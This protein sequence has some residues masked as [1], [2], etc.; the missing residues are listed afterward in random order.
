MSSLARHRVRRTTTTPRPPLSASSVAAAVVT[1]LLL[2]ASVTGVATGLPKENAVSAKHLAASSSPVRLG[3]AV[4]P[5]TGQTAP[6][7]PGVVVTLRQDLAA[8]DAVDQLDQVL[9]ELGQTA[10]QAA[11]ACGTSIARID[12]AGGG[13]VVYLEHPEANTCLVRRLRGTPHVLDAAEDLR[14]SNR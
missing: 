3:G 9:N 8:L 14:A 4:T 7:G 6:A 13:L 5:G 2:S 12:A 1:T 10:S 11:Q